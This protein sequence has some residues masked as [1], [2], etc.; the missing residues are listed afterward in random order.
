VPT[1]EENATLSRRLAER[2]RRRVQATLAARFEARCA[3]AEDH[4]K[5]LRRILTEKEEPTPVNSRLV[6]L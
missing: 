5:T 4:A 6:L 2:A 3:A 1:L